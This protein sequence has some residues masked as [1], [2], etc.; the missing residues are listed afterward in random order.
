MLL[1]IMPQQEGPEY[2]LP[3][4]HSV[5]LH[6]VE[7][8]RIH[9]LPRQERIARRRKEQAIMKAP[10]WL[11]TMT[12]ISL[13]VRSTLALSTSHLRGQNKVRANQELGVEDD[14]TRLQDAGPRSVARFL[15]SWWVDPRSYG[16]RKHYRFSWVGRYSKSS[17][18]GSSRGSTKSTP[19]GS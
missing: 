18:S 2:N 13:L 16:L 17:K 14:T 5:I 1:D 7:A 10:L 15:G 12:M 9:L 3:L 6:P 11:I 8:R 4:P 19:G